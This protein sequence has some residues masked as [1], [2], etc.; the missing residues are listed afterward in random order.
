MTQY[1]FHLGTL[2]DG[3]RAKEHIFD[4]DRDD[5]L[6]A[7]CGTAHY[8]NCHNREGIC[9]KAIDLMIT[10]DPNEMCQR[11]RMSVCFEIWKDKK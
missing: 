7:R 10:T 1:R 3:P 4:A 9:D 11:C 5:G 2:L 6:L 8:E